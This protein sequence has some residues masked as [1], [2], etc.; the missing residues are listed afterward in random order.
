MLTPVA[1]VANT[2]ITST[3]WKRQQLTKLRHKTKGRQARNWHLAESEAGSERDIERLSQ[4]CQMQGKDKRLSQIPIMHKMHK[5]R[6]ESSTLGYT[7]KVD[8]AAL[9]NTNGKN[10]ERVCYHQVVG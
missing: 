3:G 1:Q 5:A 2:E 9:M 7:Q 8:S 4:R 10:K 6:E